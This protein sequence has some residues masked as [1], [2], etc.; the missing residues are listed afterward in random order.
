MPA[1]GFHES[2]ETLFSKSK[3]KPFDL[4]V[5]I[6]PNSNKESISYMQ[7]WQS[8][9]YATEQNDTLYYW[10]I[11]KELFGVYITCPNLKYTNTIEQLKKNSGL[12]FNNED[13]YY[14]EANNIIFVGE[15]FDNGTFFI[16]LNDEFNEISDLVSLLKN[17]NYYWKDFTNTNDGYQLIVRFYL[18]LMGSMINYYPS[19]YYNKILR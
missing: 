11:N 5:G 1:I 13:K 7:N 9:K 8:V 14:R 2:I 19:K 17:N 16:Y 12:N 3:G 4:N 18:S 15:R 6:E 10:F